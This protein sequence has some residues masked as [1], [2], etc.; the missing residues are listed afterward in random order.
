MFKMSGHFQASK[1]A[2]IIDYSHS[3]MERG[4]PS[5][6]NG[7]RSESISDMTLRCYKPTEVPHPLGVR[8]F[9]SHLPH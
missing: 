5:S 7:V 3:N 1:I 4:L 2:Y 6:V 8:G 9:K